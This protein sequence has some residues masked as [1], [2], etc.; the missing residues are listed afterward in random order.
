MKTPGK[1]YGEHDAGL[2]RGVNDD[3]GAGE[4][5]RDR[6]FDK[7]MFARCRRRER[8]R[9]VL[10]VRRRQHHGVDVRIA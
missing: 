5:E 8:L 10:A 1:A 4:V 2:A 3:V 6:F 7:D 9:L